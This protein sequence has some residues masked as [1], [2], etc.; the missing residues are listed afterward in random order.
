M[1]IETESKQNHTLRETKKKTQTHTLKNKSHTHT[2][3]TK[4]NTTQKK[5]DP[6]Q[7]QSPI[8]FTDW[9]ATKQNETF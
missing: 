8:N 9:E 3:W 6:I 2:R 4:R 7:N 1:P 5:R